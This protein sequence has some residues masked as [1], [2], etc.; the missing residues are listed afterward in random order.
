MSENTQNKYDFVNFWKWQ[1]NVRS[2]KTGKV[3]EKVMEIHGIWKA[4]KSTNPVSILSNKHRVM[5]LTDYASD[6]RGF[7]R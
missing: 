6:V 3:I 5:W 2:L 7:M 4:Q 1:L